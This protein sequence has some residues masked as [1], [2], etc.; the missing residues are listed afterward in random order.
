MPLATIQEHVEMVFVP[1]DEPVDNKTEIPVDGNISP[2]TSIKS[3]FMVIR[4]VINF[5][6]RDNYEFEC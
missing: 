1:N 5:I 2:I 4:I 6:C 3:F